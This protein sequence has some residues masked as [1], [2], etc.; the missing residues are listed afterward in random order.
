MA[1]TAS[2]SVLLQAVTGDFDKKM[3]KSASR[4]DK[5]RASVNQAGKR[6]VAFGVVAAAAATAL[7]VSL[8]K[9]GLANVDATSKMA[10]RLGIATEQLER[11]RFAA[12]IGGGSAELMDKSLE[13]MAKSLG[14]AGQGLTTPIRALDTLGL[15]LSDLEKMSIDD[16]FL[17]ISDAISKL[18]SP[19]DRATA[20]T[21]L[22]GRSGQQLLNTMM[23]GSAAI[24]EAGRQADIAGVTF[25]RL[26]GKIVETAND[27]I[28]TLMLFVKGLSNQLAIQL[29]PMI[30]EIVSRLSAFIEKSG[31][32]A[33]IV[34]PAIEKVVTAFGFIGDIVNILSTAFSAIT[35]GV[36][37]WVSWMVKGFAIL[38]DIGNALGLIS[39]DTIAF[40][41]S[42]SEELGKDA[43]ANWEV[44]KDKFIGEWP[45][46]RADKFFA[47]VK[48]GA[49]EAAQ[50]ALDAADKTGEMF[51]ENMLEKIAVEPIKAIK[52]EM[53]KAIDVKAGSTAGGG[54]SFRLDASVT[55]RT[56]DK[57]LTVLERMLALM[58]HPQPGLII[59]ESGL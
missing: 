32:M 6:V 23:G 21:Q 44:A 37:K 18:D 14:E 5:M 51:D 38:A 8:T 48:K 43:A 30:T 57:Q 27:S 25:D 13:K 16:Q 41:E 53:S 29:A 42:F 17:T 45:S 56:Q 59:V 4:V 24:N 52:K 3:K 58:Q 35:A 12:Q 50:A 2:L 1:A 19:L 54:R 36:Q 40:L 49:A 11:F 26:S 9:A 46:E 31:G 28:G 15:K 10:D 7:V 33:S 55:N 47:N 22:F 39:D 34:V 20:A